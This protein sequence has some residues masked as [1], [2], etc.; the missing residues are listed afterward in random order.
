MGNLKN[1]ADLGKEEEIIQLQ[2]KRGGKKGL[3]FRIE[4]LTGEL[5]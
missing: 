2:R 4:K 1:V 3:E 5:E